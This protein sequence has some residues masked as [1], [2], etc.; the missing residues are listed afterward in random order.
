ML[1]LLGLGN[2]NRNRKGVKVTIE[3]CPRSITLPYKV[4]K[5]INQASINV[6]TNRKDS[7]GFTNKKIR[8]GEFINETQLEI[9]I[10]QSKQVNAEID[11][12]EIIESSSL[13]SDL[14]LD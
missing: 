2:R 11:E 10:D 12:I 8:V 3:Y 9:L 13:S 5:L 1:N 6:P 4:K 14:L 7:F